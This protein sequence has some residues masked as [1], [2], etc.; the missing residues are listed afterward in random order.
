MRGFSGY[1]NPTQLLYLWDLIIAYDST[2]VK[3][4][5]VC[6]VDIFKVHSNLTELYKYCRKLKL[7]RRHIMGM[8]FDEDIT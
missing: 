6:Q 2:E 3:L 5:Q 1:F 4:D 7:N 8:V